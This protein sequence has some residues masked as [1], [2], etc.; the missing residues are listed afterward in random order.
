M[1]ALD[2]KSCN[3]ALRR[4]YSVILDIQELSRAR[5]AAELNKER[6]YLFSAIYCLLDMC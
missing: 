6:I 5:A 2:I 4:I 3:S 1:P